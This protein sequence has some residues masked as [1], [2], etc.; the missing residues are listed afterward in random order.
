VTATREA[1]QDNAEGCCSWYCQHCAQGS[2]PQL[3]TMLV[4]LEHTVHENNLPFCAGIW[5]LDQ[6]IPAI[7]F[8]HRKNKHNNNNPN[9]NNPI[10]ERR[11]S[12]LAIITA[13]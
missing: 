2:Q 9:N 1:L 5:V 8:T 6:L 12:C 13:M 7:M 3:V 10:R 4:C 11:I